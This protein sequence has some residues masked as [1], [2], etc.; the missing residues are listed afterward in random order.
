MEQITLAAEKRDGRGKIHAKQLRN[1]GKV[2]GVVYGLHKDP[3]AFAVNRRDLYHVLDSEAGA[4]VLVALQIEGVEVDSDVAALVK[5]V[6]WSPVHKEPLNVDMQWISLTETVIVQIPVILEGEAP[7]VDEGGSINQI[8]YEIEV[9][10]LPTNIP[11]QLTISIDGMEISETRFVS[12]IVV[13]DGIEMLSEPEAPV[14]TIARPI[15][16]EEL[17]V[18]TDEELAEGE[19]EALELEEEMEELEEEA[20]VDEEAEQAEQPEDTEQAE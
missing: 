8:R 14:I 2:P 7:G 20:L 15:T 18:R 4:N 9:S 3:I 12:D 5:Q 13:P 1:A 17:E 6:Q 19:L 10:C 16:E 11:D